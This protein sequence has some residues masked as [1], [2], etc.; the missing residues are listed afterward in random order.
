MNC[1][2]CKYPNPQG[3]AYCGMCYE[4]LNRSAAEAF[5]RGQRRERQQAEASPSKDPSLLDTAV[6]KTA[7]L[8]KEI[9]WAGLLPQAAQ[10]FKR[11]RKALLG[12]A[13]AIA[14]L[15]LF[16]P[17]CAPETWFHLLG[18][19]LAYRVSSE[20]PLKYLVYFHYDFQLWSERQGRLDTPLPRWRLD[21]LGN[22][23]IEKT[24]GSQEESLLTIRPQEWI[25]I[26]HRG[27]FRQSQTLPL[28]HPS[29]APASVWLDRQGAVSKRLFPL[30]PR[31]AKS[32]DFLAPRFPKGLLKRGRAWKESVEWIETVGDWKIHWAGTFDW[33]LEGQQDCGKNACAHLRYK[34]DLRPQIWEAP[35]WAAGAIGRPAYHGTAEGEALFDS[36]QKKLYANSLK[37]DGLIRLPLSDVG[38]IPRGLR[39]GRKVRGPGELVLQ[40]SN[41]IDIQ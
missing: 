22:V 15:L 26:I 40:I 7:S 11:F 38:L 28:N 14:A 29:L 17:L 10:A 19:R 13:A 12:T 21:E 20:A 35:S 9:D 24:A 32:V 34:A 27:E 6:S 39:V 2:K 3:A 23:R 8:A 1:P 18:T 37:V 25:Q 5:L 36:L 16:R 31:L 41:R 4:V 33:A 30:S